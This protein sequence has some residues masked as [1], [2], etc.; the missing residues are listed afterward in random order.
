M[1]EENEDIK[2]LIG[3]IESNKKMYENEYVLNNDDKENSDEF[4]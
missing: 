4:R 2:E 1:F 3:K